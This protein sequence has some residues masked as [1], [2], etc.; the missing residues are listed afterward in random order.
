M[1][2]RRHCCFDLSHF[3]SR[4]NCAFRGTGGTRSALLTLHGTAPFGSIE[5]VEQLEIP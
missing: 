4:D 1:R 2:F 5:A 3:C